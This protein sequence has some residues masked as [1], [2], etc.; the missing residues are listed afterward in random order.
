L[1]G[2]TYPDG[3]S[4][5]NYFTW[6]D[7]TGTKDRLGNWT[8][9]GFNVVRQ[10][11]AETNA[12]GVVTAW[13]YCDCGAL[14]AITN[15]WNTSVQQVTSFQYDFQGNRTN[16]LAA[17]GYSVTNWFNSLQQVILIGDGWG[18]R[19]FYYNN[20]GLLTNVINALAPKKR[21]LSI[22]RIGRSSSPMP[23]TS[24]LLIP[25]ICSVASKHA[26]IP[27]VAASKT[28]GIPPWG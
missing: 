10:K 16:S 8:Y 17:D 18:Y 27:L 7:L 25:T 5:S 22:A 28:S 11:I 12:N 14:L 24:P 19:W 2:V 6:L 23:I 1:T 15:A 20:Q 21:Q 3:S 26:R 4:T 13:A 9:S